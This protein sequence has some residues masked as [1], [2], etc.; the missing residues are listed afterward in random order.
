MPRLHRLCAFLEQFAPPALAAVWDN[1]GL[2][3]GDRG[4]EVRKVMTCLTVTPDTATE[5]IDQRADLIVTHHP[6]PLIAT[7]R[8]TAD[9][10]AGRLLLELPLCRAARYCRGTLP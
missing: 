2:L 8:L 9:T 10:T 1:V 4:R 6:L 5:A 3:V 7:K